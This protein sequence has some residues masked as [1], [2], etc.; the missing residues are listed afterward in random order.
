ME[1][2]KILLLKFPNLNNYGT[3]M[4]GLVAMQQISNRLGA[5][6]VEF[7]SDFNSY[8]N[9]NEIKSELKGPF[10]INS[11]YD[12]KHQNKI[13][14]NSSYFSR[15]INY[16]NN[17]ICGEYIKGVD[18]IV[19]LGGDCFTE[20][21][22]TIVYKDLI[23]LWL[24][25]FKVKVVMVGQTMG[26]FNNWKNRLS[27]RY[28]LPR[29]DIFARDSWCYNY[30]QNEF[31]LKNKLHL[32]ADLAMADLPLENNQEIKRNILNTYNLNSKG[33]I[34]FVISG[35]QTEGFYCNSREQYVSNWKNIIE[36]VASIDALLTKK[37]VLLA[38]TFKPYGEEDEFV[39]NMFN[40]LSSD[41][42]SRT[43]VVS[44]RI[45][46]TRARLILGNGLFTITG[47]MHAA[48]STFQMGTPAISLAY[49]PK[50]NGVI[51]NGLKRSDLIIYAN[52][53]QLWATGDIVCKVTEKVNYLLDNYDHII[54]DIK[55]A[56]ESQKELL[57]K[58]LDLICQDLKK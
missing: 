16:I 50:Y 14:N 25:S 21:R 29:I 49:S 10:V 3:G 43:V 13:V 28:L 32:S 44:E 34:S 1:R 9:F 38:H 23:R 5:E 58:S 55:P 19:V 53:N 8:A 17:F 30:L 11:D 26:P 12:K 42:Q 15:I 57:M 54:S 35:I 7:I 18:L 48:V 41:L 40:E 37:I 27:C 22:S 52:D 6:N 33:Y 45:L 24:F 51:G 20:E 39:K 36:H 46:Q 47:R 2:K 31:S 4:M 56:I